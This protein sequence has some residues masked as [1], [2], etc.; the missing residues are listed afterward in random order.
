MCASIALYI[1]MFQL[2]HVEYFSKCWCHRHFSLFSRFCVFHIAATF[3][4]SHHSGELF[5]TRQ[6]NISRSTSIRFKWIKKKLETSEMQR[7]SREIFHRW[8]SNKSSFVHNVL[9]GNYYPSSQFALYNWM[10][11]YFDIMI[12]LIDRI[13]SDFVFHNSYETMTSK[14]LSLKAA[15]INITLIIGLQRIERKLFLRMSH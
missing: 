1:Y 6:V 12:F 13:Q 10:V 15:S 5:A 8:K 11:Q 4:E 7:I 9:Y 2:K 3:C 14:R